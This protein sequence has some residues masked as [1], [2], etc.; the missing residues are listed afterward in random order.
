[1]NGRLLA[2]ESFSSWDR[3]QGMRMQG[4]LVRQARRQKA[5]TQEELSHRSGLGLRTVR[6]VEAGRGSL[7]SLRR[8]AEVLELEPAECLQVVPCE[9]EKLRDWLRCDPVRL[10][11]S[12]SLLLP[13]GDAFV[14]QLVTRIGK[15]RRLLARE[16]GIVVPGV[17]L[18]EYGDGEGGYRILVREIRRGEGLL[19]PDR[20]MA[21]VRNSTIS[22]VSPGSTQPTACLSFGSTLPVENVS[23]SQVVSSLIVCLSCRPT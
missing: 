12:T 15:V 4:E 20:L 8:L 16:L 11:I 19:Y 22:R 10:E 5:W 7:E 6:R 1:M 23:R 9:V 2:F 14:K 3:L 17:R 13:G 18:H 21:V